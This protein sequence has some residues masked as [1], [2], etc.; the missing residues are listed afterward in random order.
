MSVLRRSAG[1]VG[2]IAAAGAGWAGGDDRDAGR[3]GLRGDGPSRPSPPAA[4]RDL[5]LRHVACAGDVA[6]LVFDR[7]A[8]VLVAAWFVAG[9]WLV[10]RAVFPPGRLA[11]GRDGV[12]R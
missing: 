3:C 4:I 11:P 7:I 1:S 9:L 5:R 6:V 8:V 2:M 10:V 12:R